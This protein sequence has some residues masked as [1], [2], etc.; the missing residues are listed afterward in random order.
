MRRTARLWRGG[1]GGLDQVQPQGVR[2]PENLRA[3][4]DRLDED[5]GGDIDPGERAVGVQQRL[6][7]PMGERPFVVADERERHGDEQGPPRW[8]TTP[9]VHGQ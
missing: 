1:G 3:D 5:H 6:D 8:P 2:F 7:L 4:H 9:P